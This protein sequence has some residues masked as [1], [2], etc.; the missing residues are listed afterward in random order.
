MTTSRKLSCVV[1]RIAGAAPST[2]AQTRDSLAF[3]GGVK[4]S[5][6]DEELTT[7]LFAG[8]VKV[9]MPRLAQGSGAGT[10][11]S[12]PDERFAGQPA[13]SASTKS[14]IAPGGR[15]ARS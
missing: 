12:T 5:W 1:P 9:A 2:D 15:L 11:K 10:V 13:K 3:A 14:V 4:R 6:T 7:A 8:A